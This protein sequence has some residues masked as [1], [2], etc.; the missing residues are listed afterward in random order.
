MEPRVSA[1]A[2]RLTI[3]EMAPK[4]RTIDSK[5]IPQVTIRVQDGREA[6][7]MRVE[8]PVLLAEFHRRNA[9]FMASQAAKEPPLGG[10]ACVYSTA[11]VLMSW[12]YLEAALNEFAALRAQQEGCGLSKECRRVLGLVAINELRPREGS[13]TLELSN[14]YLSLVGAES[15][16]QGVEPFQS[17]DALRHLR[18][19][20]VHSFPEVVVSDTHPE[21]PVDDPVAVVKKLRAILRLKASASFPHEVVTPACAEWA[22]K[23]CDAFLQ[24]FAARTKVPLGFD[25]K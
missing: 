14:V 24:E 9:K 17:V 7:S 4:K 11:S 25:L 23:S 12:F 8:T 3:A 22:L 13:E 16:N 18:N 20:L 21:K 5:P 19:T 15:W 1:I 6:H 10:K 2:G